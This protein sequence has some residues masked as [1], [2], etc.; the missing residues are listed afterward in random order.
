MN[1][2]DLT[3]PWNNL[4]FFRILRYDRLIMEAAK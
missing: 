1:V 3:L 4:V 2:N